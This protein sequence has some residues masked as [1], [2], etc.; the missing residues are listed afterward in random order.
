[1]CIFKYSPLNTK[2]TTY[3]FFAVVSLLYH[4]KS[5]AA[6]MLQSPG[7]NIARERI[8]KHEVMHSQL[9]HCNCSAPISNLEVKKK[10]GCENSN[11]NQMFFDKPI[12]CSKIRSA[13]LLIGMELKNIRGCCSAHSRHIFSKVFEVSSNVLFALFSA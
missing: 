11:E 3:D 5:L 12:S 10:G 8:N 4:V 2:T 1:M 13:V 6:C 9:S 7:V